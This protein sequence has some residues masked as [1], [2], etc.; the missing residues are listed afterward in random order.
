VEY[1]LTKD[2]TELRK[3]NLPLLRWASTRNLPTKKRCAATY[4]QILAHQIMRTPD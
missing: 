1:S 4:R 2:G 3:M